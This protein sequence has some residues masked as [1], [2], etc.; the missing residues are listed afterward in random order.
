M[1]ALRG[2]AALRS[3]VERLSSP[4]TP[5]RRFS[6]NRPPGTRPAVGGEAHV[7]EHLYD[8]RV[9]APTDQ[10]GG[11]ILRVH[12]GN[13]FSLTLSEIRGFLLDLDGTRPPTP[14]SLL[15]SEQSRRATCALN[16]RYRRHVFAASRA[17]TMYTPSGMVDGA[18]DFHAYLREEGIPYVFCSNT[19]F[20]SAERRLL[21]LGEDLAQRHAQLLLDDGVGPAVPPLPYQ[22]DAQ[23]SLSRLCGV[24]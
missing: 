4:R 6:S 22:G 8:I 9:G 3:A 23:V 21:E 16:A 24:A 1:R 20:C 2:R 7:V 18:V 11:R 12:E 5:G 13:T 10:C 19:G 14:P 17:G 15:Q